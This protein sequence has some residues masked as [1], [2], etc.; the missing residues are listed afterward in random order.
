M[1]ETYKT[2]NTW[3]ACLAMLRGV[4]VIGV[5]LRNDGRCEFTLDNADD[6]A[7]EVATEYYYSRPMVS[8]RDLIDA[9]GQLVKRMNKAREGAA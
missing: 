6:K 2:W 4:N 9:R 1:K 8:L 3:L 7:W 5:Q